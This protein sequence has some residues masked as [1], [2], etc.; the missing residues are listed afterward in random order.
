MEKNKV[1][2]FH[3]SSSFHSWPYV[4]AA[5][6]QLRYSVDPDKE[7]PQLL[8]EEDELGRSLPCHPQKAHL[9]HRHSGLCRAQTTRHFLH[10]LRRILK[11]LMLFWLLSY[12]FPTARTRLMMNGDLAWSLSSCLL[13]VSLTVEKVLWLPEPSA[14][15]GA[16]GS[17]SK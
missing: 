5:C 2:V 13:T 11:P 1:L 12:F 14:L 6:A 17:T 3:Q 8:T 7:H 10:F 15:G 16:V 9:F 4:F